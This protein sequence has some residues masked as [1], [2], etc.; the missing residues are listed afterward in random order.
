MIFY[1]GVTCKVCGDYGNYYGFLFFCS[2]QE[3]FCCVLLILGPDDLSMLKHANS[4][5]EQEVRRRAK[6]RKLQAM[7]LHCDC[8]P[9][10]GR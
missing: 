8:A 7:M 10:G 5:G 6:V 2:L 3:L 1:H 4:V 9:S